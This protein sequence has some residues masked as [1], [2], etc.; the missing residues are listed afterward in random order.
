MQGNTQAEIDDPYLDLDDME[1]E[2]LEAVRR[3][4]AAAMRRLPHRGTD[5]PKEP[6]PTTWSMKRKAWKDYW[7]AVRD[8][9][10]FPV[11]VFAGI[12][13]AFGIANWLFG[14]TTSQDSAFDQRL[15]QELDADRYQQLQEAEYQNLQQQFGGRR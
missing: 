3:D 5:G 15:R 7:Q 9:I 1:D 2:T 12:L 10:V 11:L 13:A 14:D 6:A 8:D 4:A